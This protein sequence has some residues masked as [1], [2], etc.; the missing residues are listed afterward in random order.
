[1]L[2]CR[3][4]SDNLFKLEGLPALNI[5]LY[6]EVASNNWIAHCLEM[7][8]VDDGETKIEA[9]KSLFHLLQNELDDCLKDKMNPYHVAPQEY[10]NMLHRAQPFSLYD[11]LCKTTVIPSQVVIREISAHGQNSYA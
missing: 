7:D 1:M 3:C 6:K 9:I 2:N 5:L 4:M 11:E 8:I 10:W